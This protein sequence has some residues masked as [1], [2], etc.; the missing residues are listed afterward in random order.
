[1]TSTTLGGFASVLRPEQV[2][3]LLVIPALEGSVIGRMATRLSITSA[4]TRIPIVLADP[5]ASWVNEGAEIAPSDAILSEL[6]V[7]PS[8]VAA[9][10]I[11]S[12]ELAADSSPSAVNI[13][14]AG[15]AR[16]IARKL[17]QACFAGM[18]APA[19]AGLS[20]LAGVSVIAAPAAWQNF[21]PFVQALGAVE[22]VG[23]TITSWCMSES[24]AVL[25][26]TVKTATGSNLPL[27]AA[28]S[29]SPTG[30]TISGRSVF[31]SPYVPAGTVWGLDGSRTFLVVRED[32]TVEADSSVFFTSDRH[33]LRGIM[34]V[35]FG[36]AHPASVVKITRATA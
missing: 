19:P 36:F 30:R 1:M 4:S 14:G 17:D 8:K 2:Q 18:A 12:N 25:L 23:A 27:L 34:R 3:A 5:S 16:D 33:A 10:S 35:A 20:T 32:A 29:T 6:D 15:L 31:V 11:V 9:L 7:T 22:S 24:D 21:D 28:D 13:V 26:S